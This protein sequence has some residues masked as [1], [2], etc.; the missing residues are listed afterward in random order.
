MSEYGLTEAELQR[1]IDHV[2]S[3]EEHLMKDETMERLYNL[4]ERL[5]AFADFDTAK[6]ITANQALELISI[7]KEFTS[8]FQV[9][10]EFSL[11][12]SG[13][14][15]PLSL[16]DLFAM[17]ELVNANLKLKIFNLQ[18]EL[19][20]D[21]IIT[22]EMVDSKTLHDAG[23]DIKKGLNKVKQDEVVK[24]TKK[25]NGDKTT[26]TT[27]KG[28]KLPKTDSDYGIKSIGWLLV[29]LFGAGL[30]WRLRKVSS[31]KKD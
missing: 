5:M 10:V 4:S 22:G 7:F 3:I 25:L 11:I 16:T 12:K 31:E 29:S 18:G 30:L 20:A 27:V 26:P 1:L 28:A 2:D 21:L 24:P 8:I 15:T 19:L 6:E 9:K 14:E 13:S 17:N 23:N